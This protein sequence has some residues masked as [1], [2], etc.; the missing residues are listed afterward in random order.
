MSIATQNPRVAESGARGSASMTRRNGSTG[1][2]ESAD[3]TAT[4]V[5]GATETRC[6]VVTASS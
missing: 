4:N 3:S 1:R 6:G 5:P 2:D